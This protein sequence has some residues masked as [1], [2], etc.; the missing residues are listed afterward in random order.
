M[1]IFS[2]IKEIP[3][4]SEVYPKTLKSLDD[5]PK[6]LYAV[7]NIELLKARKFTVVGSR[8]TPVAALKIGATIVKELSEA[9]TIVTGTADG[10]DGA[11]I[12]GALEGSGKVICVLAGGFSSLPQGNFSLLERV[13][14]KGL[15]LSPHE[16]D[17][18]VRSFSYEYRNKLLAILG[19]G[20]LVLGA[21][22]KSGALI[23][24]KYAKAY[25]K[26]LFA[27]PYAPRTHAGEGCNE[28]IK[29]GAFLTEN[30]LDVLERFGVN[31]KEKCAT[32]VLSDDEARLLKVLRE[33]SESHISELS[34]R[35][36][37]PVFKARALLSALEVRGVIVALGGNRYSPI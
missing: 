29:N 37:I 2:Q 27:L 5:A 8:T 32:P 14:K 33:Q 15:L 31:L 3:L 7:G 28:L 36:G 18:P 11:A 22:K 1:S 16:N 34:A 30:S 35:T 6:T 23:T 21:A 24:A 25:E 26:P 19:E 17:A 13:A 20:T 12:E 4:S 9:F 10:G